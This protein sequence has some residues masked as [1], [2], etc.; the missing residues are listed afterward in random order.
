M[1]LRAYFAAHAPFTY[2]DAVEVL[3]HFGGECVGPWPPSRVIAAL[4]ELRSEY[5]E[6]MVRELSAE[7]EAP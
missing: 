6:T 5:A 4:C 7:Q 2:A 3:D 1:S